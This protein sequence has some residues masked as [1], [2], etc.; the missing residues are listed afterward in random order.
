METKFQN[1]FK[2]N[3]KYS[4]KD[5]FA[6]SNN[7]V[8]AK[9]N[10]SSV[11]IPHVCNNVNAFGAGFADAVARKFPIV[12][13]N[14]HLLRQP[15]IGQ[16]QNISVLNN[17]EYGHEL[18]IVNMICQTG[19]VGP[20]N[21]RPLNYGALAVCMYSVKN[22]F[23]SIQHRSDTNAV[24]IHAPKF[25]SGLAGGDWRFIEQLIHDIWSDCPVY[26]YTPANAKK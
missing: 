1:K 24:E 19:L 26:I 17:K 8:T 11:I 6:I 23:R 5:I 10:G 12:K 13:Q 16:N 3:I 2:Y 15:V 25:G 9:E 20:K 7:R 14:F 21:Q 4:Q 22:L 18:I